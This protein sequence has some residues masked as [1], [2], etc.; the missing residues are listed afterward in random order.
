M[1]TSLKALLFSSA[2]THVPV[3]GAGA[4]AVPG[5]AGADFAQLLHGTMEAPTAAQTVAVTDGAAT[6][7]QAADLPEVEAS[8]TA[9]TTGELPLGLAT[10][11]NAVQAHRKPSLPLPPGLAQRVEKAQQSDQAEAEEVAPVPPSDETGPVAPVTPE[12]V[13]RTALPSPEPEEGELVVTD[14]PVGKQ[15]KPVKVAKSVEKAEMATTEAFG[16]D[17]AVEQAPQEAGPDQEDEGKSAPVRNEAASHPLPMP[18]PMPMPVVNAAP[19]PPPAE[20]AAGGETSQASAVVPEAWPQPVPIPTDTKARPESPPEIDPVPS[21]KAASPAPDPTGLAADIPVVIAEAAPQL[22]ES[23]QPA[24]R[25]PV[26]GIPDAPMA[27][28]VPTADEQP[29]VADQPLAAV[30]AVQA[31]PMKSEALALLQ[32]VRDQISARQP[33]APVRVGEQL[34]AIARTKSDRSS[35]M[36]ETPLASP[37]QPSPDLSAPQAAPLQSASTPAV[38]STVAAAPVA[39]LSA[40]LGAQVV[41]MGVSG[42][43]IDGLAR[44][45]AGLSANG[46]QGRFQINADQLGPVQVDIRHGQEGAS[47]SLTV[48]SA[49]AETALRQDSDRL[50]LDAGL[51]A[52]RI[53]DV[54]IERAP[55]V[56]EAARADGASQQG[57]Q[58]QPQQQASQQQTGQ[59]AWANSQNM[60]QS[61]GQGRWRAQENSSFTPKNSGDPAVLNHDDMRRAGND[62][63][64]ARY[65]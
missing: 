43:W 36:A 50:R 39:D 2:A 55:H 31:Q 17:P 48:A 51:A 35:R 54:K 52:V 58:Q 21:A 8:S 13:D 53:T 27:K 37:A 16:D 20:A 30:P 64:R 63:V 56:A 3:E 10:A 18:M 62:T 19:P 33:G 42:Q 40:S 44:D 9:V 45:I 24:S 59:S 4:L 61:Q 26:T 23:S 1:L 49:A 14:Q 6:A 38:P 25:A 60:G 5:E 32:M 47:V 11:L 15:D 7:P 12:P 65:A 28:P 22:R 41:D 57:S 34:S 29:T 46:A